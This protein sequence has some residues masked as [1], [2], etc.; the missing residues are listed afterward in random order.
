MFI[1][2]KKPEWA[3]RIRAVRENRTQLEFARLFDVSQ[4]TISR[5]ESGTDEPTTST[6]ARLAS[7]CDE[8]HRS[9]FLKLSGLQSLFPRSAKKGVSVSPVPSV[10]RNRHIDLEDGRKVPLLRD[11]AYLGTPSAEDDFFREKLLYLPAYWFDDSGTLYAFDALG[12]SM[13][14]I[15]SDGNIVIVDTSQR[16]PASLLDKMVVTREYVGNARWS[17]VKWL[18]QSN[19]GYLLLPERVSREHPVQV[20]QSEGDYSLLGAVVSWI[21]GPPG[22]RY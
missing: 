4:V 14:P 15:I 22:K 17:T 2:T 3:I 5:W 9:Y 6:F 20:M 18:R 10:L 1:T 11:A 19:G 21:G 12:D 16:D 8:P 13:A 7:F